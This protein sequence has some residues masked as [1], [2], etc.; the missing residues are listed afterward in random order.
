[1]PWG[2][3]TGPWWSQGRRWWCWRRFYLEPVTL[4]KEEQKKILEQQKAELESELKLIDEKLKE[5][6]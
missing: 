6:K 1:M 5:L 2:D 4:T 3:G